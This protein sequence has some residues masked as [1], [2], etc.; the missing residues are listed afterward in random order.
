MHGRR[1]WKT[2]SFKYNYSEG[3]ADYRN[4]DCNYSTLYKRATCGNNVH[5]C[6][7]FEKTSKTF[8]SEKNMYTYSFQ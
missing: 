4:T 1:L 6:D 7:F 8:K 5:T 3:T 2:K